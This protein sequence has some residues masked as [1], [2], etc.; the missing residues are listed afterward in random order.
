MSKGGRRSGSAPP[1]GPAADGAATRILALWN[2]GRLAEAELECVAALATTPRHF[3]ANQFLGLIAMRTGRA[4]L[5]VRSLEIAA[6]R[7]P[8]DAAVRANLG[9]AY[10]MAGRAEEALRAYERA[11]ALDPK[12]IG[13]HHNRG[14]LLQQLGRH[15]EAADS[16]GRLLEASPAFAYAAGNFLF[17]RRAGLDWR[18]YAAHAAAIRAATLA[19]A[20]A[21]RPFSFLSVADSAEEQL[22]CARTH[23][24]HRQ[25][26]AMPRLWQ[27][28]RYGHE[29][30]RLAYLSADFRDHV[31]MRHVLALFE[32]HDR[33]RFEVTGVALNRADGSALVE[34]AKG[35]LDRFVDGS[36]LADDAL[37]ARL[38]ELEIDIAVDLTSHTEGDRPQVLGRR[39]APVQ[40]NFFG[41]PGTSGAPFIDYLIADDFVVPPATEAG[42]SERIVRLPASFQLNGDRATFAAEPALTRQDVG[43][44]EDAVVYCNFCNSYKLNPEVFG[45]WMA[46]L[47]R[48]PRA[49][50]WLLAPDAAARERLVAAAAAQGVAGERLYFC[51]RAT[52]GEYFARLRLADVFLDTRPFNGGITVSDALWCG[53]P[54]VTLAG[55]AFAARAAGSTLHAVGL[56]RLVADSPAQFVDTAAALGLDPAALAEAKHSL[57]SVR[58]SCPLFDVARYTR[59]LERAFLEMHRQAEAGGGPRGFSVNAL[60]EAATDGS[61]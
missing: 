11:L 26:E 5:A 51:G 27:G 25:A 39:P 4:E 12:L 38:H 7:A 20:K 30:I 9:S 34:R 36:T 52:I 21:D 58:A 14:S 22:Q 16:F 48:V 56:G 61:A 6:E 23:I 8:T 57:A 45:A 49:I 15:D 46:V 24:A 43:L 42:Y 2:Q 55:E 19:G 28:R 1:P 60:A 17:S 47:A 37:A 53:V 29:R 41:Y 40:V 33:T 54:V 44:P 31:V 35:A 50:L 10:T 3:A 18:D 32:R 13:T 59:D